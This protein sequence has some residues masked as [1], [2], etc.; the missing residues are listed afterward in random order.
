MRLHSLA[1]VVVLTSSMACCDLATEEQVKVL[2]PAPPV[3]WQI[4]FPRLGFRVVTR[5]AGNGVQETDVGDWRAPVTVT[6][7]RNVNSPILAYPLENGITGCAVP[8]PGHLRPAG[9]FYPHSIRTFK[10]GEVLE[11]TWED[12]AAAF[13]MSRVAGLDRD[14][15]LF[16]VPRLSRFLLAQGDP[17]GLDL[18]A[19]AQKISRGELTAWDID[20]LPC[21][22]AKVAPGPGTWFLESPF[23]LSFE[24][25]D[26]RIRMTGV[27]LGGHRLYSLAGT[28]WQLEVGQ[29][30]T[31]MIRCP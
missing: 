20:R 26:G 23:S 29:V 9:G 28:S 27:S 1:L 30:E 11:L 5:D 4:A 24:A 18:D 15:S 6:C 7:A 21:R 16:N 22:D 2:L 25:E 31:V 12:G 14:L 10:S 3:L 13:V 17:W 8:A 19:V